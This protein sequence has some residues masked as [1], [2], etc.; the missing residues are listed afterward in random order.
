MTRWTSAGVSAI[1]LAVLAG[2]SPRT[3]DPTAEGRRKVEE[4]DRLYST[5]NQAEAI[6][7]YKQ[8]ID[9]SGRTREEAYARIVDFEF[10]QGNEAEAGRWAQRAVDQTIDPP[11]QS[12][13]AKKLHAQLY[14]KRWGPPMPENLDRAEA[15][16]LSRNIPLPELVNTYQGNTPVANGQFKNKYLQIWFN[17]FEVGTDPATG[18]KFLILKSPR[19]EDR[20]TVKCYFRDDSRGEIERLKPDFAVIVIGRGD[21]KQGNEIVLKHCF[22]FEK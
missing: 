5:G 15:V 18:K 20:L 7:L 2:C 12:P 9:N 1:V 8:Y 17:S 11:Y 3:V 6:A 4:A 13:Q 10:S 16:R 22:I 14:A 21:G 19:A